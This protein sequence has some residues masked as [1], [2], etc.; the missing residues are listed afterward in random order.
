LPEGAEENRDDSNDDD[1]DDS[2][3]DS[4]CYCSYMMLLDRVGFSGSKSVPA[5]R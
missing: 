5:M 4:D 1:D 3:E 2:D